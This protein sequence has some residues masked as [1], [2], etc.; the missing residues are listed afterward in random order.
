MIFRKVD[1]TLVELNIYDFKNDEIYYIK[2]LSILNI[3]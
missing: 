3:K 1:G 2:I